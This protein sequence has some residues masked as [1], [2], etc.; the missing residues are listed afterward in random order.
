MRNGREAHFDTRIPRRPR[1]PA[2][3]AT[4]EDADFLHDACEHVFLLNS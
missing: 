1:R 2:N 4:P 3:I